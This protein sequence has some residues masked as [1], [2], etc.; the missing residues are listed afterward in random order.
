MFQ[1]CRW[2]QRHRRSS[3]KLSTDKCISRFLL[4]SLNVDAI[5]QGT[6]IGGRR[7]KLNEMTDNSGLEGA[8]GATLSRIKGQGGEKSRL[9]MAALMWIS[10]SER[11]LEANEL[12][13]ALGVETGT[14]DL[15]SDKVPSIRTLLACCQGLVS[16]DK[17]STVRL[18]HFTLL[19]YLRAHPELFD[20]PHAAMA[21]TCLSY[22]SSRQ[23]KALIY[24]PYSN[25]RSTPFLNYSSLY[26]GR[27]AK[28]DLSDC[29]KRLALNLFAD[30]SDH[31]SAG[32]LLGKEG[33]GYFD[34]NSGRPFPS[35]LHCASFFGI[36]ELV[37]CLVEVEG[38]DINGI[39]CTGNTPLLW[40]ASNGH[41]GV[42]RILL[43]RDDI[44]PDRPDGY[45]KTPLWWAASNGHEGVV[46]VLLRHGE[47][48]PEQ[49]LKDGQTPLCW[50]ASNG[51]EGVV[52]M[53]LGRDDVNPDKPDNDGRT[54]LWCAA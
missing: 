14:V 10:H 6:T 38:C 18:I 53:L 43:G 22:L 42:V 50:A 8:Y 40:A 21:E 27:H 4:V 45:G 29:T 2:R 48:N 12:L 17:A 36:D 41:E 26:W 44:S 1:K 28:R 52:K 46:R 16:V 34:F 9:G 23:V 5:L 11:P 13:H 32:I 31:I 20:R 3:L 19:E 7:K 54:P 51:H 25:F 37:T 35:G 39:D 15:D 33:W 24:N 47:V 30:Y 49:H